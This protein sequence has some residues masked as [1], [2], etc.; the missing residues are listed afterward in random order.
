M[1][2]KQLT[3]KYAP[4]FLQLTHRLGESNFKNTSRGLAIL[5]GGDG[6]G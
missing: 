5:R 6:G 4:N 3:Q 2:F 1:L